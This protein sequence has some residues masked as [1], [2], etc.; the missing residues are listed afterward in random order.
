MNH[1]DV[2]II[3][4]GPAGLF[5]AIRCAREGLRV[6]V[7][8]K[9]DG[10]GKK[11]LLT[12]AGKCNLTH[13]GDPDDFLCHYGEKGRFVKSA[14][15]NFTGH[16]LRSYFESRNLEMADVYDG[17]IF[18][19]TMKSR[20]VLR[21]LLDECRERG[22]A[23]RLSDAVQEV[24][25]G[26]SGFDVRTQNGSFS[27]PSVV[28]ATGGKSYPQTGSSGD[29]YTFAKALGHSI[30]VPAPALAPLVVRNYRF[31]TCAGIS[32]A[33]A[34]LFL[35]R[36]G[37]KLRSS[38]GDV[39]FT[40]QGLSGPGILDFSRY[41]EPGDVVAVRL[42][43][44]DKKDDF[45]R[46]LLRIAA[47]HGKWTV[48]TCMAGYKV[49][50]RLFDRAFDALGIPLEYASSSLDKKTRALIVDN[51][52]E[53]PF[54][55][56]RLGD[57]NEA[58]V[59]RGGVSLAEVNPSTLASRIVPRLYFAGEVLDVDGDTGGYNLQFAFSSGA[60]AAKDIAKSFLTK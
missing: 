8:E 54:T 16:N 30:A 19:A 34:K 45:E 1:Y 12:G 31:A 13:R 14:L 37:Q 20:D 46:D 43:G 42:V 41:A 60:L 59:T 53:F 3:G 48:K 24:A 40:H 2:L 21:V 39:L 7:L 33:G 17:K 55:V 25:L 22:V 52:M 26:A 6:C 15:Y 57:Y 51:F 49:P 28:I 18:P 10:A 35:Y 36:G 9:T 47:A 38:Q 50:Q 32:L 27:A 29:G 58:M 11:L 4:A 23:I 56:E 44:F 5:C